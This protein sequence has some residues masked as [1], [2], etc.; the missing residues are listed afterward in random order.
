M[1]MWVI[2]VLLTSGALCEDSP[3]PETVRTL[4]G[5]VAALLQDFTLLAKN[6][7]LK[8]LRE[9]LT[10][11]RHEL[12][13]VRRGN[14]AASSSTGNQQRND[15]LTTQWLATTVSELRGEVTELA[16]SHNTSAELQRREEL[17]SELGLL[18]GDV[19]S[20]R[21]DLEELQAKQQEG[22]VAVVQT[23]QD[24]LAVKAQAQNVAAV[25]TD[26]RSQFQAAQAE[27]SI[28][29]KTLKKSARQGKTYKTLGNEEKDEDRKYRHQR[30]LR[31]QI[32]ELDMST[33]KISANQAHLDH[34]VRRLEKQMKTVLS[35][36]PGSGRGN[37]DAG[38][39]EVAARELQTRVSALEQ[40]SRTAA[41]TVFNMTRQL[42][43]MDK[44]HQSM[45]Q[46][47]E[48]VET[49]ENKVDSTVPDLQREISKM[50]F[51]MA[52]LT[53]SIALTKEDQDNQRSSLKALSTSVSA[54]Q[55]QEEI[56]RGHLSVLQ[57]QVLN[58]T[59]TYP[60]HSVVK[61]PQQFQVLFS[62]CGE[63][64]G[65]SGPYLISPGN[66]GTPLLL[67][68]DQGTAPGGWALVQR[69]ID[70]SQN[71]N[72]KWSE[73]ATGFGSPSGTKQMLPV[74][75]IN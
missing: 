26:T 67:S 17:N 72:R 11:L 21:R 56:D 61:H 16:T 48:S 55:E 12:E 8:A 39:G 37:H 31:M 3:L 30:A 13:E 47:L 7:E 20:V 35:K 28:T 45:L 63:V 41:K 68:C 54:I 4:Q 40:A 2:V 49:L 60:Q 43:G 74:T 73:Y 6:S 69:R 62:D 46:L 15:H 53:S 25:C 14:L 57:A 5:Q 9:E 59:A 66:Q 50:E 65:P 52:Q 70:G 1:V 36:H 71:F 22:A 23:Q 38:A 58:F 44:L 10:A 34:Q 75:T 64:Q 19:A 29:L 27:W 32:T 42:V 33:K 18:R 51:N 24:I